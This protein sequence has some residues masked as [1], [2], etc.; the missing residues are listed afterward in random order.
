MKV[1]TLS[2]IAG[3][4]ACNARCP[5]C[6]AK[7]TPS[8][9]ITL[10]QPEVNW[11]NLRKAAIFAKQSDVSTVLI[12]GKGEPT[13]FPQQ[14]TDYLE[15]L[16]EFDFPFIEIQTNGLTLAEN[17]EQYLKQW[18]DL[19]LSTVAISIS[20]YD[21]EKNK[22]VYTPDRP[23]MNLPN[24]INKL[25]ETGLSVRLTCVALNGFIDSASELESIVGF[26]QENN[27]EQLT[28]SPVNKPNESKSLD[29]YDWATEHALKSNQ[30]QDISNYL[31]EKGTR[32]LE[33][34]HGAVVYD[35]DGQ[36]VCL[37]NCLT[38]TTDSENI[39][40]LIFFPDGHLRYDWEYQG[41]ILL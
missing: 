27:V 20:H 26:A 16:S 37:N 21:P 15:A 1:Q 9:G 7:M 30:L 28:I 35:V 14:I 10:E 13:L 5:F 36:N 11:R 4:K 22:Q 31:S 8:Q 6:V 12:T 41:A 23:Y 3:S 2:V 24:L 18:Y 17:N 25:H 38:R 29:I 39:R 32:L 40:Q 34:P 33:L 19:G